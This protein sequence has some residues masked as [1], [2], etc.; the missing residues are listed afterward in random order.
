MYYINKFIEKSG[1]L[2]AVFIDLEKAFDWLQWKDLMDILKRKGIDWKETRLIVNL[3]LK[4]KVRIRL[5]NEMSKENSIGRV[6]PFPFA[7]QHGLIIDHRMRK[8][9][10]LLSCGCGGG[11]KG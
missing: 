5:G 10:R 7:V 3:Y 4:Q 9:S 1:E 8:G 11:W 2:Y 6:L